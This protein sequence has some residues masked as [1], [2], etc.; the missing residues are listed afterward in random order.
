MLCSLALF[1]VIPLEQAV[2]VAI[3]IFN[4]YSVCAIQRGVYCIAFI[5]IRINAS[6]SFDSV[7]CFG[8]RAVAIVV[9]ALYFASILC[10]I[11]PNVDSDSGGICP[12][13]VDS[14][15]PYSEFDKRRVREGG[16][17]ERERKKHCC[18][19]RCDGTG[20]S[21]KPSLPSIISWTHN[22]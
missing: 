1:I 22:Y 19:R 16:D 3:K 4:Q 5:M 13:C 9:R 7:W 2:C 17:R 20:H 18:C 6:T 11:D 12:Q 8:L 15:L 10:F 21:L 14:T